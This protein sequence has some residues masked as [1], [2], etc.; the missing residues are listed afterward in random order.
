MKV[1]IYFN[2]NIFK[3]LGF[4]DENVSDRHPKCCNQEV[5]FKVLGKYY[6]DK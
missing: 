2:R 6:E 5:L 1:A 3:L 4:T